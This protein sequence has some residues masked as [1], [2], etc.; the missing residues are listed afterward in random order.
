MFVAIFETKPGTAK[1]REETKPSH[2]DYWRTRLHHLRLAGPILS[3]DG[4]VRLGQIL[5][6]D[7][8]DK[9]SAEELV[10]NDPFTKVGLFA[11]YSIQQFRLSVEA[12]T[13]K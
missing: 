12:G 10:A 5:V 11:T 3:D 9:K 7:L 4:A 6:I 2:D 1:L 8:P 13:V